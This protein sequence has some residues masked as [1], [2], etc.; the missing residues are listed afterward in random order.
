MVKPKECINL[1]IIK[2]KLVEA[3]PV[4][5]FDKEKTLKKKLIALL[6]DDGRGHHHNLYADRLEYFDIQ[7]V[8]I[9]VDPNFTAAISYDKAIIYISEGFLNDSGTFFQLN[10]LL[11]HELAHNLLMH[12]VRMMYKLGNETFEHQSLSE[13]ISSL[14]NIIADDE[15][16]NRK[17]TEED[18]TIVRN[19]VLNGRLISGLV[20]EDHRTGWLNMS[21]EEMYDAV[22]AEIEEV[23]SEILAGRS[24]DSVGSDKPDDFIHKNITGAF[25]YTDIK[26]SSI[27]PG[28]LEAFIKRGCTIAGRGWKDSYK[29]IAEKLFEKMKIGDIDDDKVKELLKT[30]ATSSPV[31][32]LDLFNN[33]EIIL[34][35]P[36]EKYIAVEVLKKYKSDYTKW[37]DRVVSSLDELSVSE[38]RELIAM[39]DEGED[40]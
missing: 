13:I 38:I 9:A 40:S 18:K 11:R 19:M 7:I 32:P 30:V 39:L 22:T 14:H 3:A 17:Y 6:R 23:R 29:Q 33:K 24:I 35:T 15:I 20:T 28:S 10:V 16:S 21:I 36:E 34:Y 4:F 37:L 26:S 2:K 31:K 1:K 25:I 5:K 8:P 12:Q 27:I